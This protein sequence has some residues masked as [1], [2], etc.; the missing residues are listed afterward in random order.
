MT[1]VI[2]LALLFTGLV[3]L[4]NSYFFLSSIIKYDLI[5]VFL[6]K[7]LAIILP[8]LHI[9]LAVFLICDFGRVSA[10]RLALVLFTLYALV[11]LSVVVRG[12]TIDCGCF[13]IDSDPVGFW[14]VARVSVLAMMAWMLLWFE[15]QS[16]R[17]VAP[18]ITGR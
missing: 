5:P 16:S 9:T 14:S 10:L 18:S 2:A 11:Q 1:M 7:Q 17:S 15:T 12:I 4:G 3:H 13:G 6:A 8:A